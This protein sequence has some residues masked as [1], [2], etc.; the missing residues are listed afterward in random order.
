[1]AILPI[2]NWSRK[3]SQILRLMILIFSE[4]DIKRK[5]LPK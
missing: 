2:P 4:I 1:M 3:D 5:Q